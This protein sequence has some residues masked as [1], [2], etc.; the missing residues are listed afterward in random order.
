MLNS[1]LDEIAARL[2]VV[3]GAAPAAAVA[4]VWRSELGPQLAAG[5]ASAPGKF[6]AKPN[7][8]FDLA[9]VSKPFLA[10]TVARLARRGRLSLDTPL[11]ALL[12]EAQNTETGAQRLELLLAHRAGLKAHRTLFAPLLREALFD[13]HVAIREALHARRADCHGAVPRE[14]YPPLYSDLGYILVGAA[15]EQLEQLPLDEIVDREISAPLGLDLGSARLLHERHPDFAARCAPTETVPFRGG[16]L[17]GVVHDENAWA[18]SGHGLSGHAG[19]FGTALSVARFGAALLDAVHGRS[20]AWLSRDCMLPLLRERPGGTLRAGFDGKSDAGSS[21]GAS[22]GPRSFGHLG[23]TGTSLWCD[24]DADRAVVL[25]SNRVCPSRE[26]IRI[27]A[28]RP[29]VH[30]AV[31]ARG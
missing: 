19:L 15:L 29:A 18:L 5:A 7:S 23:F 24:P 10:T 22:A 27:R 20:D 13:R 16:E 21:A 17:C 14:G 30:D 9:S 25:L 26:N 6:L 8:F 4:V 12:P 28:A 3:P 1:R 2:V 31:F 11:C